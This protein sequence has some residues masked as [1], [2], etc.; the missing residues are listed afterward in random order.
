MIL[1]LGRPFVAERR[2][3]SGARKRKPV[4]LDQFFASLIKWIGA[5]NPV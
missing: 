4:L 3:K 1:A 5:R 2:N